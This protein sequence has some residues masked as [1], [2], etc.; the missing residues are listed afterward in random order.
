MDGH[1]GDHFPLETGGI[2][3]VISGSVLGLASS[4]IHG[5]KRRAASCNLLI[6][7]KAPGCQ[8]SSWKLRIFLIDSCLNFKDFRILQTSALWVIGTGAAGAK[9]LQILSWAR[10]TYWT[11][12]GSWTV[13][14]THTRTLTSWIETCECHSL[15]ISSPSLLG[16]AFYTWHTWS[17]TVSALVQ[18]SNWDPSGP[19][20]C[21][22]VLGFTS[23]EEICLSWMDWRSYYTANW[24]TNL[25][26]QY[27]D[28]R[29]M[30]NLCFNHLYPYVLN[31][32]SA[33]LLDL[34]HD[35]LILIV[36]VFLCGKRPFL[37]EWSWMYHVPKVDCSGLF[38]GSQSKCGT[39]WTITKYH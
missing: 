37:C 13:W 6:S 26:S 12:L 22:I 16:S 17:S 39:P 1:L 4:V 8:R 21:L 18:R 10:K 19:A 32:S 34:Q 20:P 9:E 30:I 23:W 2:P 7:P 38:H 14:T 3:S 11:G 29:S 25:K 15:I 5:S 36:H 27:T 24:K 31:S 33:P 35:L 28:Y